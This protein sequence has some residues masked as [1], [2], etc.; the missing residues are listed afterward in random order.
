M[1]VVASYLTEKIMDDIEQMAVS[2]GEESV[3]SDLDKAFWQDVLEESADKFHGRKRSGFPFFGMRVFIP[4]GD[5]ILLSSQNAVIGDGD[6]IN[7]RGE[8]P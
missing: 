2:G 4:E 1:S 7:I 5:L 6:P 3:V 8:I